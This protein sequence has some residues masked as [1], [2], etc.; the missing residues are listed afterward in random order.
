MIFLSPVWSLDTLE[1]AVKRCHR[2]GQTRPTLVQTLIVEDT[3]EED[4]ANRAAT[5]R[6][7]AEEKLYSR[8]MLE[9]R[10]EVRYQFM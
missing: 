4:I 5:Q 2:L 1:Q 3:I 6:T 7:E 10:E 9:V 8:A